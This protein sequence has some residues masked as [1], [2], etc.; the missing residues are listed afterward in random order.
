[1]TDLTTTYMGL[2]LRHPLVASPSPLSYTF[3]GVRRLAEGGVSAIVLSSLFAE[4]LR[5][6]QA[7]VAKL[8]DGPAES[9][10]EALD[11]VPE[12]AKEEPGPRGAEFAFE[13]PRAREIPQI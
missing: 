11:Y 1:M 6:Y 12:V 4:Q 3:D 10:A 5:E 13:I 7:H 2:R 9:F 8:V